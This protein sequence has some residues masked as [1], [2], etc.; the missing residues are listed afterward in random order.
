MAM[1][2]NYKRLTI[3]LVAIFII[4]LGLIGGFAKI[5]NYYRVKNATV[6]VVLSE[7]LKVEVYSDVKIEDFIEEI[8]GELID[9]KKIDTTKIG[10]KEIEF[11]YIN[12]D[13]I[14]VPYS[15]SLDIIDETK[16]IISKYSKLEVYEG[17]SEFYK[18]IFCG[19]NYDS[20]PK[21]YIDGEYDIN[22]KGEYKV[23]FKGEDTSGNV[24][25][26][27]IKLIVKEKPKKTKSTK[28]E[29]KSE[30]K[31]ELK[32]TE[33]K[34]I[35]ED[36]KDEK[37]KVGI[38]VSK[39]QGD[40]NFNKVKKSGVEFAIIKVGGQDGINGDLVLDPKFKDN[41]KGFNK[42]KIPVGIYF[43]SHA[44]S[45]DEA[46][47]QAKWVAKKIKKYDV[48]L[49]VAFDWENWSNYQTYNLSFHKLNSI[50]EEFMN[51][52]KDKDYKPV[53][54]GSKSYLET[55]WDTK[56][57]DIWLANYT[58]KTKYEDDFIIWQRCDDG[59]VKGIDSLVDIDILY[60]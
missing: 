4:L 2:I 36:F 5:I 10:K 47:N 60:E 19:D 43:Y 40:I 21:C 15:Y 46:R 34:D 18:D 35:V 37:V 25:S 59:V 49:P 54:Y 27:D 9:N 23:T 39:W 45:K 30:K 6:R 55:I 29:S 52:I 20:H 38:D 8:N 26:Q 7:P 3:V 56:D 16:P 44:T 28:K 33:F 41:I 17:D 11:E 42:A 24:S 51:T 12:E 13:G 31:K 22:K 14:K 57:K 32:G 53:L 58:K 1:K 50:A 48:D